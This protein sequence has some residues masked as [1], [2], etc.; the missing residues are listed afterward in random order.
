VLVIEASWGS[1]TACGVQEASLA[2]L[3][4]AAGCV[5]FLFVVCMGVVCGV[6]F[7]VC[8]VC[9]EDEEDVFGVRGPTRSI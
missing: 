5:S 6:V 2:F 8:E 1:G 4:R 3:L 9:V 7:G